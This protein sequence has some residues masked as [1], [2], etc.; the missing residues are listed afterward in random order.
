MLSFSSRVPSPAVLDK[1]GPKLHPFTGGLE[2]EIVIQVWVCKVGSQAGCSL[3]SQH[4]CPIPRPP[5]VS[6]WGHEV[7]QLE[8]RAS[9]VGGGTVLVG[10]F[11]LSVAD[12]HC[13]GPVSGLLGAPI[14]CQM[15]NLSPTSSCEHH[16]RIS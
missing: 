14:S 6:V 2:S 4:A 9:G 12:L 7:Q 3:V 13:L 10:D 11:T 16:S 1:V 8:V 5:R 15:E